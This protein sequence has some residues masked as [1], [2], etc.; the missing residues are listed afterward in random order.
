MQRTM[1]QKEVFWKK[2]QREEVSLDISRLEISMLIQKSLRKSD[3]KCSP[4]GNEQI[5]KE[6][7]RLLIETDAFKKRKNLIQYHDCLL[8]IDTY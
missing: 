1:M 2:L 3:L 6:Q 8:F 4:T 5:K 7:W